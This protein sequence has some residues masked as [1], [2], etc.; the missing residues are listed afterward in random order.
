MEGQFFF[1]NFA[2]MHYIKLCCKRLERTLILNL[3]TFGKKLCMWCVE[4][5]DNIKIVDLL[6]RPDLPAFVCLK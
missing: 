4:T 2:I 3:V 1:I 5:I 6:L